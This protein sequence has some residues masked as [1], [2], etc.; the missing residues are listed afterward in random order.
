VPLVL[1]APLRPRNLTVP[2]SGF[3][4]ALFGFVGLWGC[5]LGSSGLLY[6]SVCDF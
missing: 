4:A 6:G 3:G 2:N 5:G 1:L